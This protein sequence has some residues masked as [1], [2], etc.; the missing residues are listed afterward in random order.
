MYKRQLQ[1][2]KLRQKMQ[3]PSK[4]KALD[5][6]SSGGDPAAQTGVQ[7]VKRSPKI[8]KN[9]LISSLDAK[10]KTTA[11]EI[12]D[13]F[14]SK[15]TEQRLRG[16]VKRLRDSLVNTFDIAAILKSVI[17]GI[18]K[19]LGDAPNKLKGKGG[20]GLLGGIFNF[21]KNGILKL[22][23]GLGSKTVSYTHL[24]LPTKA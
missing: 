14:G 18:T 10:N 12:L 1:F 2:G 22:I 11:I 17:I 5:F 19:Q 7:A 16:S 9:P 21:L 3:N 24:T 23:G 4:R 6:L 20:G 13:F 15:R 8:D